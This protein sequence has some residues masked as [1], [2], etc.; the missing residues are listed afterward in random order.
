MMTMFAGSR[1][2]PDVGRRLSLLEHQHLPGFRS[3]DKAAF[4]IVCEQRHDDLQRL[5]AGSPALDPPPRTSP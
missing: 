5:D 2:R 1:F 4:C 3:L